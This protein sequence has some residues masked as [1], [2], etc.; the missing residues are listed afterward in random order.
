MMELDS[1]ATCYSNR[2]DVEINGIPLYKDANHL[3]YMG[4]ELIGQLYIARF[5]NPLSTLED[6]KL[7]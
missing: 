1:K 5:G 7:N 6:A 2:G 4:S 3:N